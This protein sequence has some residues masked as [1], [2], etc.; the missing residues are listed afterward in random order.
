MTGLRQQTSFKGQWSFALIWGRRRTESRGHWWSPCSPPMNESMDNFA[1]EFLWKSLRDFRTWASVLGLAFVLIG[2]WS[3]HSVVL[4]TW[5]WSLIA[6]GCAFWIAWRA[7]RQLYNDKNKEVKCDM[8]LAQVVERAV[9]TTD[10][11][12][13]GNPSKVAQP[14][15]FARACSSGK[16]IDLGTP[17]RTSVRFQA[18]SSDGN[19]IYIL[20]RIRYWLS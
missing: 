10:F 16:N 9:G 7:E 8:C 2:V 4:P 14:P 6:V 17:G 13:S 5:G 15:R 18:L 1:N 19:S 11:F 3:G 20:G 12:S